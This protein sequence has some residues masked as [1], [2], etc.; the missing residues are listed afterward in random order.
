MSEV[1]QHKRQLERRVDSEHEIQFALKWV[2]AMLK[3]GL[4]GGA[5]SIFLGRPRRSLDQN[6]KLWP[7][8]SDIAKQLQWPVDGELVY[9]S[10]EDW[11]DVLTASLRHN[12]RVA[13]GIDGGF[14]PLGMR[15]SKMPKPLFC[16]LIEL[17]YAFGAERGIVWSEKSKKR[18]DELREAA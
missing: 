16:Q 8:L 2:E 14:V 18:L 7:M 17:M 5:M 11:K 13:K 12:Q 6:A 1:R 10:E 3:K 4:L 15:T 9:M